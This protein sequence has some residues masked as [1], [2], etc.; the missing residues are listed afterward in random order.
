MEKT[1]AQKIQL[2]L[3]VLVGLII[4]IAAVYFIGKKQNMFGKT[5]SISSIFNNVNGLQLGNNVRYSGI[6]VGTVTNIEMIN[7]TV[8]RVNMDIDNKIL[9]Y[10]DK[11]AVATISSDGLV[12]NKIINILPGESNAPSVKEGD[13]IK[14]L[15]R[16][17]TEDMMKTLSVTN[18]NAAVLTANLI[19]ITKEISEGKGTVGMLISDADMATD[20][21]ETMMYL[22]QTSQGI[23]ESATSLNQLMASLNKK[24]N[25]IGVIN[26]TAAANS[27]KRI[28]KNLE[29][30]SAKIDKVVE[31]LNATI[32]NAKEGK[33]ALNYL[34]NNP[35][36]V[37]KIDSTMTNINKASIKLNENMEAMRH[38]F[39]F[40]GYFKKQD[41]EKKEA[42]KKEKE[43]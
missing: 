39:L 26:D 34:S 13:V 28:V 22:K 8:I 25:V 2:G 40:K 27:I 11:D 18:E 32:T 5:S 9:P 29:S 37:Q 10:I 4:F 6:N 16:I 23:N 41:K 3:F 19:K 38:N 12:G 35:E 7:D 15:S 43:K 30:S 33:G 14:S 31:N 42:E 1:N 36:L 24:D 20:L 17:R 21:K